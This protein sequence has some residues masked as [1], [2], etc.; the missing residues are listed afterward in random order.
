MQPSK[1]LRSRAR[2]CVVQTELQYTTSHVSGKGELSRGAWRRK[3]KACLRSV[4]SSKVLP[5]RARRCNPLTGFRAS[6][7]SI[8]YGLACCVVCCLA[9]CLAC[10]LACCLA[11]V[12]VSGAVALCCPPGAA[13][14]VVALLPQR[15]QRV[16]AHNLMSGHSQRERWLIER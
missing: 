4:H 14:C 6:R 12:A 13:A 3:R 15:G 10:R 2:C 7:R 1:V 16:W 9:C 5:N 11:V 8:L